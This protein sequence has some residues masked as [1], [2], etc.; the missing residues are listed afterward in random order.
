MAVTVNDGA[1]QWVAS[2]DTSQLTKQIN[3]INGQLGQI[4]QTANKESEAI[5]NVAKS[6]LGALAAFTSLTAGT[7]FIKDIIRVRGEFQQLEVAFETMLGSKEKADKLMAEVA[8]FAATTPFELTDVA[9]ATKLLLAFGISAEDIKDDLRALGDVSAGVGQPLGEIA[10]LFGQI[11]T[12]GVA[13]T[14]DVRQFAQRGIPIYEELAKV[15]NVSVEAVG[16]L[17]TAGKVGFPEIEAVFKNLTAE[18]SKFGGLMEKQSHT[19]VGQIS[20][21][22]DA[23]DHMLNEIGKSG[24]GLFSDLISSVK[25][26]VENFQTVIDILK[27]LV[28][29]YGSYRAAIVATNVVTAISTA[30]SEGLTLKLF[31]QAKAAKAAEVIQRL[32]NKTMLANP[33]AAAAA[34]IIGLV[35]ALALFGRSASLAKSKA[36]LLNEAQKQVS[37]GVAEQQAKILPYVEALKN[38]NLSEKERLDIYTKL[39]EIDPAI[40]KGLTDK[41]ITYENLTKNVNLYIEALKNQYKAEVNKKAIQIAIENQNELQEKVDK[42]TEKL[43]ANKEEIDKLQSEGKP[44]RRLPDLIA[45]QEQFQKQI[46]NTNAALKEQNDIINGLVTAELK[47]KITKEDEAKRTEAFLNAEISRLKKERAEQATT[48]QQRLVFTRQITKLEEELKRLV[49]ESNKDVKDRTTLE[50][51][52]LAILEKKKNAIDGIKD[53]EREAVQSGLTDEASEIDKINEKRDKQLQLL[54]ETNKEIERF[55]KLNKAKI[56]LLGEA[57]FERVNKAAEALIFNFQAKKDADEFLKATEAKKAAFVDFQKAVETGE[58]ALIQQ[59]RKANAEQLGDFKNFVDLLQD[60]FDRLFNQLKFDGTDDPGLVKRFNGI[61]Q[62][63][64]NETK[65]ND[66]EQKKR[67]REQ[68]EDLLNQTISFEKRK[69]AI[70]TKYNRLEATLELEKGRFSPEI[71][72]EKRKKLQNARAQENTDL[73]NQILRESKLYQQL[74]LDIIGFTRKQIKTQVKDLEAQL[75]NTSLTP[76][77]K[78]DIQARIDQLKGILAATNETAVAFGKLSDD[79][80]QIGGALGEAADAVQD[81]NQGLADTLRALSS[82]VNIAGKAAGA[83]ASFAAGDIVGGITQ[84][85]GVISDVIAVFGKIKKSK[86]D[87]KQ[88][89]ADFQAQVAAGEREYQ[90]MIR[91]RERAEAKANKAKLKGLQDE[92]KVL[93]EQRAQVKKNFDELFAQI[94]KEDFISGQRVK[95]KHGG[96]FGFLSGSEVFNELTSLAGKSFEEIEKL[97]EQGQLTDKAKELFLELQKA[98]DEG[99]DIDRL[100]E[101]NKLAAQQLFTGTTSDNIA[102]TIAKGLAEGK[103]SV[104]DFA[105]DFEGFMKDAIL[106]SLKFKFLEGPVKKLFDEFAAASESQGELTTAEIDRLRD[107]YNTIIANAVNQF[108]QLQQIAGINFTPDQDRNKNT[109]TGAIKGITEQQAELLAGQFGGLRITALQQLTEARRGIEIF[110]SIESNTAKLIHMDQVLTRIE[111][112]GLKVI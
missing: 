15:L 11:K 44:N 81:L 55:N 51:Q 54:I 112:I 23:F 50:N 67:N 57:E 35:S 97:F 63:L 59:S 77:M 38:A 6:A 30:L 88:A 102:D 42:T 18:G 85:I 100:L 29:T 52:L 69:A 22:R 86:E 80:G 5:S 9:K 20:N 10:F 32:L 47:K 53:L 109:L 45:L 26:L 14:Q 66:E 84:S 99:L 106:N 60:E 4:S 3:Q 48:Q 43:K 40:V 94:Q 89:I 7:N 33:Y 93:E 108:E 39:K 98:R 24:E 95:K 111:N 78:A 31:L 79:L 49:G 91:D 64:D 83:V 96:V 36:D 28:I 62:M 46:D 21:L 76:Q 75:K 8:E 56:P 27:V 58:D 65:L 34:A 105:D 87:A 68:L 13:M 90:A 17:I 70:A 41:T 12:Q 107:Q 16:D 82:V 2:I 101:E 73:E 92:L 74:S 103:R 61:K 19:L 110:Q 1:L 71:F 25:F 37:S 104:K 72:E